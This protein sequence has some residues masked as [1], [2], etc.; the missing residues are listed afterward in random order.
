MSSRLIVCTRY[1]CIF[2]TVCECWYVYMYSYFGKYMDPAILPWIYKV[3]KFHWFFDQY[4][5]PSCIRLA[6]VTRDSGKSA[7]ISSTTFCYQNCQDVW[8]SLFWEFYKGNS[9]HIWDI[10]VVMLGP[11]TMQHNYMPSRTVF[12]V[13]VLSHISHWHY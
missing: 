3:E 1:G 7:L 2:M 12:T 5:Y 9:C 10:Y 11:N 6:H 13:Y 8:G 4:E